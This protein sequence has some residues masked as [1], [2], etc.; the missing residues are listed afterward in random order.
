MDID[1]VHDLEKSVIRFF[2]VMDEWDLTWTGFD[3]S[4]C[5]AVGITPKGKTCAMEMKFRNT[6]YQTK[7]LEKYKYDRLMEMDQEV[8]LYFVNDPYGN[9][10][11]WLNDI[12]LPKPQDMYCPNTTLWDGKKILKPC[13]LLDEDKA[14]LI[15]KY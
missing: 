15:T 2:N 14:T 11:F 3:N 4:H 9:Y 6:W 12:D 5:D 10:L 1:S 8:K 7:M 13:Y